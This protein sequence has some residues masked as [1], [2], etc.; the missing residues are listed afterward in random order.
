MK[1][2]SDEMHLA[3]QEAYAAGDLSRAA[4]LLYEPVQMVSRFLFAKYRE[5]FSVYSAQDREDGVT[6][7]LLYMLENLAKIVH[8]E[9][10]G[11]PK[12]SFY[13]NFVYNGLRKRRHRII[14]RLNQESLDAPVATGSSRG[15]GRVRIFG[16]TLP[17]REAAP[18]EALQQRDALQQTLKEFFALS[19][20]PETLV[21]VAFV[22]LNENLGIKPMSMREYVEFFNGQ[23]VSRVLHSIEVILRQI[24][25]D[26]AVLAPLRKRLAGADSVFSG[27]T[28][29][30]LA[31]RKNSILTRLRLRKPDEE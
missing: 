25:Q 9:Q 19:N 30:R 13:Y 22:I 23:S 26:T 24:R 31:N 15:D 17:S 8:P 29:G 5:T 16:D 27:W 6:D 4:E 2:G 14:Q 18:G 3:L 21:A 12:A 7:A 10:E 20:D 1:F 11:T 28:E